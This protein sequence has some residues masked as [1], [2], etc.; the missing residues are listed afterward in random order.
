MDSLIAANK[1]IYGED[2]T[3]IVELKVYAEEYRD[4]LPSVLEIDGRLGAYDLRGHFPELKNFFTNPKPVQLLVQLFDFVLKPEDTMIDFYAGSGS[5][6]EAVFSLNE[7]DG[8]RRRF[9][10]IQLPEKTPEKHDLYK[11]GYKSLSHFCRERIS[12]AGKAIS[13]E[14]EGQLKLGSGAKKQDLGF[15]VFKLAESNFALWEGQ[16]KDPD[17]L[18]KQLELHINHLDPNASAEDILYELLLKA[19]FPLTTEVAQIDVTGKTAYSIAD[20][21]LVICLDG[22]LTKEAIQAMA[23]LK[24]VQ[25]ICLD[26]AFHGNDQLKTNAVQTMEAA[27]VQFR[28]V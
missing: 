2:H 20:G 4:K 11:H 25:A 19:G 23:E 17:K 28:T 27:K 21:A 18:K 5:S 14:H 22:N 9:I 16:E 3:K 7:R 1:I 26:A 12:R 10:T 13:K 6:A 24:P 15:R 8:G